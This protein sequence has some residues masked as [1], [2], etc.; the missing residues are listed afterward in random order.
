MNSKRLAS[1]SSLP[2]LALCRPA[3]ASYAQTSLDLSPLIAAAGLAAGIGALLLELLCRRV[4]RRPGWST[5]LVIC[6]FVTLLAGAS[7]ALAPSG[8]FWAGMAMPTLGLGLLCAALLLVQAFV[9]LPL[10]AL[11]RT[12][13][14]AITACIVGMVWGLAADQQ[15]QVAWL[16]C[17][18]LGLWALGTYFVGDRE[19]EPELREGL[20]PSLRPPSAV[21]TASYQPASMRQQPLQ[22]RLI[23]AQDAAVDFFRGLKPLQASTLLRA[24]LTLLIIH[25]TG[26]GLVVLDVQPL[27]SM[28]LSTASALSTGGDPPMEGGRETAAAYWISNGLVTS[29]LCAIALVTVYR[30]RT[31]DENK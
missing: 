9:W 29:S 8:A 12:Q 6:L 25:A 19:P 26:W 31:R 1:L 10:H 5:V 14:L 28:L 17:P 21:N 24:V 4:G 15:S 22:S 30:L 11:Q 13:F 2:L 16:I 3:A 23:K 18:L 27:S 20:P 7:L